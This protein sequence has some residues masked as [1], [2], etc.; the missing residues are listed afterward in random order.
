MGAS[1]LLR[2]YVNVQGGEGLA[3]PKKPTVPSQGS[4]FFFDLRK[5]AKN[6]FLLRPQRASAGPLAPAI[7]PATWIR[8]T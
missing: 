8:T 7:A 4:G 5:H 6:L 1:L 3:S 2:L